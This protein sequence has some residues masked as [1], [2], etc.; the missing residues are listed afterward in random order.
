MANTVLYGEEWVTKLQER[1]DH[2]TNWKELM[3][4]SFTSVKVLN[5]P[6]L[7][8]TP[9][10]QGGTRGSAYTFQDFGETN[11][12]L[13]IVTYEVLPI[14]IDQADLAQSTFSRQMYWAD[15]QG[16]LIN[17][18]LENRVLAQHTNWTNFGTASIG[19]GGTSSSQI[20]VSATNIDDIIRAFKRLV[21]E[22]NGLDL[23]QKNGLGIVWRPA[24]FEIL[25]AFIQANGF[26]TADMALKNGAV[27][28]IRY[29]GVDHYISNEH[30]ANHVW[31][32][33]KKVA[34]L[35]ILKD[36]FG[37]VKITQDP[38]LQS[39]IG[40]ISRVDFGF[41]WWNNYDALYYDINVV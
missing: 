23:A 5:N 12:T 30:A 18:R 9:A 34:T 39:G 6:F 26:T 41:A 22:A 28:G 19:G 25:E 15:L 37:Q 17:E 36:T 24:D 31:A 40:V 32:T 1:L 7:S 16:Q 38:S 20:T 11:E 10:V 27:T 2:P 29:M 35:G 33:V 8:T 4:V 13:D 3:D 21:N 14:F